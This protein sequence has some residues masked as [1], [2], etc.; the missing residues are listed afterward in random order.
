M[1]HVKRHRQREAL[2]ERACPSFLCTHACVYRP[3]PGCLPCTWICKSEHASTI[4]NSARLQALALFQ[5]SRVAQQSCN[6]DL[7]ESRARTG[8]AP[9]IAMHALHIPDAR[10]LTNGEQ[11]SPCNGQPPQPWPY[12]CILHSSHAMMRVPTHDRAKACA[13]LRLTLLCCAS[14][15][16]CRMV[17][18][19]GPEQTHTS[20]LFR[21]GL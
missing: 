19:G 3:N 10:Q 6:L 5:R 21:T 12:A 14:A 9:V 13:T 20:G 18:M 8:D 4:P 2:C 1:L 7:C 16:I 11:Q 17:G 15:C